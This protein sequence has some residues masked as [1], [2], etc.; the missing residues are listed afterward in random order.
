MLKTGQQVDACNFD[1]CCNSDCLS[2]F[3]ISFASGLSGSL[4]DRLTGLPLLPLFALIVPVWAAKLRQETQQKL[5]IDDTN[6]EHCCQSS[7]VPCPRNTLKRPHHRA[8]MT[9]VFCMKCAL[10]QEYK[11]L[12]KKTTRYAPEG[13]A[14]IPPQVQK[15]SST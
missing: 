8:I 9:Y 2:F 10:I 1:T 13:Y 4:F 3:A 6:Q 11:T 5:G 7:C 12:A 15:M 14:R